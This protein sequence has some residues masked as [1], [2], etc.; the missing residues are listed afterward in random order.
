[1]RRSF[2]VAALAG[3]L[4]VGGGAAVHAAIGERTGKGVGGCFNPTD[5]EG[6][7]N[8]NRE[9]QD[10]IQRAIDDAAA[11]GGGTVCLNAGRWR[12]SRAKDGSYNNHAALSTHNAHIAI[13]GTGPGTVLDLVG[14]QLGR[15]TSV[16]SL[17]PGASDITI[18]RLTIDTSG[19][20]NT[21]VQTHGIAIGSGVCNSANG[22]CSM[23]VSDVTVRD[24]NFIHPT[25]AGFRK[26]DCIRI[27]G[28]SAATKAQRVTIMGSSFTNCARSGIAVQRNV[29]SLAVIGNHFGGQIGDTPFDGEPTDGD[30][31]N[32][33]PDGDDGLR[34]IGNSFEGT[35]V[36]WSATIVTYRHVTI[37]GNTFAGRGLSLYRTGDVIVSDNTF[38]VTAISG[39]GVIDSGNHADDVKIHNN[40]I[41]RHGV[42]GPG[43]RIAPH[44]NSP[45][46]VAVTNNSITV[47][48]DSIG[49]ISAESVLDFTA[50]DNNITFTSA[51]PN[52]SGVVVQAINTPVNSATITGNTIVGPLSA[53]GGNTYFAAVRLNS[54]PGR[55]GTVTVALNTARAAIRSLTCS[56]DAPDGFVQPIVSVGN[57]WSVAPTCTVAPLTS[58]Q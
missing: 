23:P 18:D 26:G 19:A 50:R 34:L 24:V 14:D 37:T 36:T 43:V 51:A 40:V 9:D 47:D 48:G 28:N 42:G 3:T 33:A 17:D 55:F 4:V 2:L 8:D 30:P 16:I 7:P 52:A 49:A 20:T 29:F 25:L 35:N 57:N 1:V 27:L 45:E 22:T 15:S 5:Y 10:A 41:R 53:T 44:L 58:G 13:T 32:P 39:E 54:R 21:D 46:R 6:A 56:E 11:A 38:D 31:N 12:L